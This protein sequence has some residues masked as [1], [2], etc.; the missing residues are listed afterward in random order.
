MRIND[1]GVTPGN[2]PGFTSPITGCISYCYHLMSLL[3]LYTISVNKDDTTAA[4][5]GAGV[6]L[7][8]IIVFFS[9]AIAIFYYFISY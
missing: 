8:L 6:Y 2:T 7:I 3:Q 5:I 4:M 9:I 1:I